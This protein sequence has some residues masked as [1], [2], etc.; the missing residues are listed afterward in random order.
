MFAYTSRYSPVEPRLRAHL[1]VGQI[2]TDFLILFLNLFLGYTSMGLSLCLQCPISACAQH[3]NKVLIE[4]GGAFETPQCKT[5]T[6][7]SLLALLYAGVVRN[8][9]HFCFSFCIY[10]FQ[11]HQEAKR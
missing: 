3:Y 8:V 9:S 5:S 4:A 7:Q 6:N 1:V 11:K 2:L 10:N